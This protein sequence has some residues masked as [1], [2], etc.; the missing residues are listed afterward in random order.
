MK[1]FWWCVD[2][3]NPEK[4]VNAPPDMHVT[5]E[6]S[7]TNAAHPNPWSF[8]LSANFMTH[9]FSSSLTGSV[10]YSTVMCFTIS[11]QKMRLVKLNIGNMFVLPHKLKNM[12]HRILISRRPSP[13]T[14]DVAVRVSHPTRREE[15]SL[16][17]ALPHPLYYVGLRQGYYRRWWTVC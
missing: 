2:H 7:M 1:V 16:L 8:R 3:G 11:C 9:S 17:V 4:K 5:R 13:A 12:L 15:H 14:V 6:E 10:S